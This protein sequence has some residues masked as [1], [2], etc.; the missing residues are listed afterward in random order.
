MTRVN[1]MR[2]IGWSALFSWLTG[3]M[4]IAVCPCPGRENAP[5]RRNLREPVHR[6]ANTSTGTS[7]RNAN[8]PRVAPAAPANQHPLDPALEMASKALVKIQNN[9][10][11]YTC[12]LVKQERV[13]GV[14]LDAEYMYTKIRNRRVEGNRIVVPFSVYMRFIKPATVKGREVIYVENTNSGKMVAHEGGVRGKFLPTVWLKPES[15]LAMRNNRYPI[16]EVGIVT[17]TE[18][19]IERGQRD[20]QYP[21]CSV[22]FYENA[23]LNKRKC[24]VLEVKHPV[25]RPQ[26]DFFL[27]RIFIDDEM[28]VPVRYEAYD[29]PPKQGSKPQLIESYTY[30]NMKL[31][32]GLTDADFDHKNGG[33]NF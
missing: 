15:S 25:R 31:N 9:I 13:N 5:N 18:R 22:N 6:V 27:A 32:V 33:Y 11:D 12:T 24:T 17:L 14:V 3:V 30:L 19:L 16:T 8:P 21:D 2:L 20:R 7:I 4:F 29:W 10:R 1:G 26:Y 23:T 28:G